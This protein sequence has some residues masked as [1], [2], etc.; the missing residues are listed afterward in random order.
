MNAKEKWFHNIQFAPHMPMVICW[1]CTAR[2]LESSAV[3]SY[4]YDMERA[5][6]EHRK[7]KWNVELRLQLNKDESASKTCK[8]CEMTRVRLQIRAWNECLRSN[9][10]ALYS[11][12]WIFFSEFYQ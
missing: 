10:S 4:H 7:S 12:G 8:F 9:F 6:D 1:R 2:N 3:T 11:S 5:E